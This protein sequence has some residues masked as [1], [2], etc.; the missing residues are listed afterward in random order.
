MHSFLSRTYYLDGGCDTNEGMSKL[1]A[2]MKLFEVK[3]INKF[4]QCSN[5]VALA[6]EFYLG[7]L[8]V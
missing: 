6:L 3:F 4:H 1:D 5:S 2:R 8:C 7:Y